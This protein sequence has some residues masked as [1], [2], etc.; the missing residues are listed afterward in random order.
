MSNWLAFLADVKH[1]K[2]IQAALLKVSSW[3]NES[4]ESKIG[5]GQLGSYTNGVGRTGF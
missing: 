4:L 5:A 1:A 3:K 2:L